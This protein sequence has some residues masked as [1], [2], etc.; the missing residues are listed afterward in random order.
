MEERE[1]VE[2]D[3]LS[4]ATCQKRHINKSAKVKEIKNFFCKKVLLNAF[5]NSWYMYC[6]FDKVLKIFPPEF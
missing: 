5:H 6:Q 4:A 1:K 3:K 2:Q